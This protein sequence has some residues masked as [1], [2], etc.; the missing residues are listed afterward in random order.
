MTHFITGEEESERNEWS[1]SRS[2]WT[3]VGR[4]FGARIPILTDVAAAK[5]LAESVPYFVQTEAPIKVDA[6]LRKGD[7]ICIEE[8]F[9]DLDRSIGECQA[10]ICVFKPDRICASIQG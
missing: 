2:S 8:G 10:P 3:D 4:T 7:I 6:T 9:V 5:S 1:I